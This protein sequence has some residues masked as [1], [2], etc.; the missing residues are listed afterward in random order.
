[1]NLD[2]ASGKACLKRA[3][4]MAGLHAPM[5]ALKP[6]WM[7]G[8]ALGLPPNFGSANLLRLLRPLSGLLKLASMS[9]VVP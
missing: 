5:I 3:I 1:M 9:L 8:H 6:L 7:S 4:S 2:A